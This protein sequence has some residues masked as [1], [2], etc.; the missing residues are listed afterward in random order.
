M[1]N[2]GLLL[3]EIEG[4]F[5]DIIWEKEPILSSELVKIA[6]TEFNW[7]RT[8][9]HNVISRLC[10]KGLF[11]RREDGVVVKKISKEDFQALQCNRF[12]DIVYDGSLPMFVSG[13]VRRRKLSQ[14]DIDE[15]VRLLNEQESNSRR[16]K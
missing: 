1:E 13:F 10:E 12:V 4:R 14:E 6:A 15:I 7:K 2:Q 9:T 16:G 8:T 11:I 5:A 3:G